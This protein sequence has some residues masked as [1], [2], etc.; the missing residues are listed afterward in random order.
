MQKLVDSFNNIAGEGSFNFLNSQECTRLQ[1]AMR[2][3]ER[4]ILNNVELANEVD[5]DIDEYENAM[6]RNIYS[7]CEKNQFNSAIFMCGIAHR[8]S[9]IEMID[10]HKTDQELSLNWLLY[11]I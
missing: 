10:K 4:R 11:E 5:A 9:I 3:E 2:K 1:S 8:K 7:Y 6:L